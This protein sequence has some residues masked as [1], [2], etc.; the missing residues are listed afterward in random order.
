MK[1]SFPKKTQS[2]S[3]ASSFSGMV[4][5]AFGKELFKYR[6]KNHTEQS[7]YNGNEIQCH[8][9]DNNVKSRF[10]KSGDA[11]LTD[12]DTGPVKPMMY[13]CYMPF[14]SQVLG[15]IRIGH[16]LVGSVSR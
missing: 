11:D 16:W 1:S 3:N 6:F 14:P 2:L 9:G 15:F 5:N 10:G 12:L 4:L 8:T 7:Q 13:K